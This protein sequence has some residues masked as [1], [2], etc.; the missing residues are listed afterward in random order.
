MPESMRERKKQ[1][2]RDA[3]VAAGMRLFEERGF[4]AV[5]VADIATEAD[6]AARTFHRYFPDKVELLFA[7]DEELRQTVRAALQESPPGAEPATLVRSVLGAVAT[8]L[9]G[10]HA[11]LVVRDRLLQEA[12]G[13]RDRDLA[14]RAALEDLV[15]EHLAERLGVSVDQ[16]V[17]PR[18]WAGV[19][20]VTF[21]A[22]YQVWL[23][24]GGDLRAHLAA[25][26]DLLDGI[27]GSSPASGRI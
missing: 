19:A 20:F 1:R 18:W 15:A 23:A 25:A 9:A 12:P 11:E 27:A 8:R 21:T 7:P 3:L 5:T 4:Q 10:N 2:T 14:K 22:G 16:D 6:I 17:R 26:A 24:Q 13:L